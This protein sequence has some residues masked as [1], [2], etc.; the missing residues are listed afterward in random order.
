MAQNIYDTPAFFDGYSR[1]D[2][3]VRGLD[4]A[5]EWPAIQAML[6]DLQGRRVVDLGC[7]FGWFARW[8]RGQGA[9]DVL[10]IDLSANM[11]ARARAD[12]A[13]PAIRYVRADLETLELPEAAFELA[14][15]ALAFHYIA[16]FGR[17]AH[18]VFRALVPGSA[19]VLS[20]EHPIY[21]ASAQPDWVVREDGA[22][23]WPVDGY[24]REGVR[25]TDWLAP[26][27]T[28]HHRTLGTTLNTLIATGFT[29]R[30]IQEWSPTPKQ[31]A[32]TPALAEEMDRPMMALI[33]ATR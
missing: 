8:A 24:A 16:D 1:L 19:F 31:V 20:I 25:R 21:M 3:S 23:S 29:L 12:T 26:G 14:Y 5:P 6:P 10:G 9:A 2:R 32:D 13:D 4:G 7:G 18:T 28:K 30:A 17:L 27:V 33:A 22:R 11:L 15:S